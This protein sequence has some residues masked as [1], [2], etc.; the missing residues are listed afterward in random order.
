M[1][2]IYIHVPF[3]R[4]K[5]YYCD[6]Y[7][8]INS[9]RTAN[10][11]SA[12]KLEV[13]K[14]NEYLSGEPIKTI[15]FGG[16][17]PSVLKEDELKDILLHLNN[18]FR[19]NANAEITLEANPDDLTPAYLNSI[20]KI[21][22]NRLSIGIQ[23]FNDRNL[24]MMNRRHTSVQAKDAIELA[25]KAGFSNLSTDLI[26][27][28]PG[29]T[30]RQWKEDLRY[31]FQLP[32]V[33]LSAYHLTYHQGTPFFTWLKK[34]TLK[35]LSENSS[36]KQFHI[37]LDETNHA[38]FEQYEISNFARNQKYSEHNTA[39]W[40]G[41]KYL[42]LGPSAHSYDGSSRRWNVAHL[43]AYIT[44]IEKDAS[45][46]GE[47]QLSE[48]TK[49]NEFVLTRIRT[50]WGIDLSEIHSRFGSKLAEY[51][52]RTAKNYIVSGKLKEDDGRYVLTRDGL[53]VSDN[54]MAD[55]MII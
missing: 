51:F 35:E 36:I 18:Y 25:F 53:F 24:K 30:S 13:V 11:L 19:V 34:G 5:C 44:G 42:G 48:N 8:T 43:D 39:Y 37:L 45:Y 40:F 33:H 26:Y 4:Q 16:G 47:E 38:G 31:L 55:F 20:K 1:A 15:Y 12:L 49:Y 9:S 2:G 41:E 54:L 6:F 28:L 29:L 52:Q 3:C 23:S 21:G 7:K 14:R 32:I 17:T 22:I 27:G 50:R 46:F 10:F